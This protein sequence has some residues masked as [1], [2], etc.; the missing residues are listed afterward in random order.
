MRDSKIGIIGA[1][2][3]VGCTAASQLIKDGYSC[4]VTY[5]SR[6]IT[7]PY[8]REHAVCIKLDI[9]NEEALRAFCRSCSTILN[10]AG[11][12]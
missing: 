9:D 5:R 11:P 12:S 2:G 3:A 8:I 1:S 7:D 6:E 10:C 4:V